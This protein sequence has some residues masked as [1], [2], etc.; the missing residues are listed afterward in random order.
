MQQKL[1]DSID[2]LLPGAHSQ[3]LNNVLMFETLHHVHF[4]EKIQLVAKENIHNQLI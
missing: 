4:T 1:H 3:Q 2:W